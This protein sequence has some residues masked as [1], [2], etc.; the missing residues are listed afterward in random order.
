M[1]VTSEILKET[2][3]DYKAKDIKIKRMA[4]SGSIIRLTKDLYETNINAEGYLVANAICSP[5]YLS[6]D[7]ALAFHGMIP[8]TVHVYTSASFKKR[9]TKQYKNA[10]GLFTYR[11]VPPHIYPYGI[12]IYYENDYAFAIATPEK[13][14]C[15]KLYTLKPV[16]NKKELYDLLFNDLRIDYNMIDQLD[17]D[18]LFFLCDNYKSTNMKYLKKNFNQN[19]K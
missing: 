12:E 11:D 14:I 2:L 4:D 5:S 1:I 17:F 8:E 16:K 9:K 19:S 7:Y 15:D 10:L 18:S 3:S 13:A 6:F